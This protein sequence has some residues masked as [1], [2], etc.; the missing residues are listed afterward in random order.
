M[1]LTE[2]PEGVDSGRGRGG[3][4]RENGTAGHPLEE[5]GGRESGRQRFPAGETP[6]RRERESPL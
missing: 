4:E 6:A 5:S 2:A 3:R 1:V